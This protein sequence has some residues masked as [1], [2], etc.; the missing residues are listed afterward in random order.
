MRQL[1]VPACLCLMTLS[2][3][4][5]FDLP[6]D[7]FS[8]SSSFDK[9]V[10]MRAAK[11]DD[12]PDK[13]LAS[14]P[15]VLLSTEQVASTVADIPDEAAI[16]RQPAI[17]PLRIPLPPI[18][19]PII[20]RS[21]AEICDALAKAA[22]S[23]ALPMPFFIRLLFQESRFEPGSVSSA[24]AEGIAQFMPE[25]SASEGLHNPFDPLEAIPASA[26]L[27]RKLFAQFG[28]L[29]LAAAA[30]N[31]GP[32]RIQDW[33]AKKGSLPQETR[34]Y[35]KTITGRPAETWR[36]ARASGTQLSLPHHAPCKESVPLAPRPAHTV[37]A[38]IP[39]AK[40]SEHRVQVAAT[41]LGKP[42]K[43]PV[44]QKSPTRELAAHKVA[45]KNQLAQR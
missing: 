9:K 36:V 30:Y 18:P 29:G 16:G 8:G 32:K 24:G 19:K 22:Q 42:V 17:D 45:H 14:A 1:F 39:Q 13:P 27:L 25:T 20:N 6:L 7:N 40:K 5:G 34:G 28:N 26:R 33:I 43:A 37:T 4:T 2:N 3:T 35:V 44:P 11:A 38:A 31:A 41:K 15:D 10:L 23:N 21:R 12:T